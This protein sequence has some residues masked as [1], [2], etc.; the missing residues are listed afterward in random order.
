MDA[1]L[2]KCLEV[3]E[4]RMEKE[5]KSYMELFEDDNTTASH[6]YYLGRNHSNYI[7][8]V[9]RTLRYESD[10]RLKKKREGS[11]VRSTEDTPPKTEYRCENG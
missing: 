9:L 10:Y 3:Q 7:A 1:D 6:Y 2:K 5:F 11:V 8:G 4:K